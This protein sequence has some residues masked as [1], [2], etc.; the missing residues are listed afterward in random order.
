MDMASD[1][2]F[3]RY[4]YGDRKYNSIDMDIMLNPESKMSNEVVDPLLLV[5]Q[6]N[7]VMIPKNAS[8]SAMN[9]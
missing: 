3:L 7:K 8:P 2:S 9:L 1:T 6:Y 5:N 4:L